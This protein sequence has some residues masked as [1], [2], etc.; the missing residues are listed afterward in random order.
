MAVAVRLGLSVAVALVAIVEFGFGA[1]PTLQSVVLSP[2]TKVATVV[3]VP[4]LKLIRE[5]RVSLATVPSNL[6][7]TILPE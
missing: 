6:P 4:G 5:P 1:V 7:L 2:L 3:F